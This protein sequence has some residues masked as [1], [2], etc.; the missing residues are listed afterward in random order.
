DEAAVEAYQ[1][2]LEFDPNQP[3]ALE[4]LERLYT[5]LDRPGDLLAVSERKLELTEDYRA[6]AIILFRS[7]AIWQENYQN[8]ANV[9]ACIEGVRAVDP[10]NLQA[11]KTLTRLRKEQGRWEELVQVIGRHIQLA[12]D[13]AEQAEL[14]VQMGEVFRQELKQVDQAVNSY[15]AA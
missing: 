1:A 4:A 14:Y 10:Q 3:E 7:A 2:A 6:R 12:V 13:P 15:H 11:I 5:K 8:P 9:D